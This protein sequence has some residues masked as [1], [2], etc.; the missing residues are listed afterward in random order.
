MKLSTDKIL[1][2]ADRKLELLARGFENAHDLAIGNA[3]KGLVDHVLHPLDRLGFDPLFKE[4]HIV[5]ATIE[6]IVKD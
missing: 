1:A 2:E 3:L 4:R 6:H 5:F